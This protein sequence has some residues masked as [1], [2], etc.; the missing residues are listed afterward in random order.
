MRV[1]ACNDNDDIHPAA[2]LLTCR[3]SPLL[4]YAGTRLDEVDEDDAS[5]H[6]SYSSSIQLDLVCRGSVYE[7]LICGS[8]VL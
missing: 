2:R 7:E 6:A 5:L 3:K 1:I 8:S 4:R